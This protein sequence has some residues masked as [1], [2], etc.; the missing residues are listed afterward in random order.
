MS[1]INVIQARTFQLAE[2][3]GSSDTEITVKNLSDIYGKKIQMSGDIQYA[4]LEP[5][6]RDNQEIISFTWI[7]EVTSVMY[8]LTGVTRWLD[9]QPDP[10]TGLYG[11]DI[12]QAK[13]HSANAEAILSDNPQ[14]WDKKPSKDENETITA[15]WTFNESPIVPTP[16]ENSEAAT[17][18][19][20]DTVAILWSA[21]ATGGVKGISRLSVSPNVSLGA[22]TVTIATPAVF[23]KTTHGLTVNDTV[24]FTT[25]GALPTGLLPSV[26]YYVI[27]TGH[28]TDNFRVSETYGGGAVATSGTQSGTHAVT[29]TTPV[30]AWSNDPRIPTQDENDALVGTS[31]T[32][33][34]SNPF[35]T[36]EDP[37]FLVRPEYFPNSSYP[38]WEPLSIWNVVFIEQSPATEAATTAQNVWDITWNTRISF[39][40]FG[41]WLSDNTLKLNMSKVWSPSQSL[42]VR[43][44]TDNA[45]SPSG[46][47]VHTNASWTVLPAS[48]NSNTF[49]WTATDPTLVTYVNAYSWGTTTY[50][51]FRIETKWR[52]LLTQVVK[53]ALSVDA[54]VCY[55]KSDA[56]ATLATANFVWNIATFSYVLTENTFYRI[57][58]LQPINSFLAYNSQSY[59]INKTNIN[60]V[61]WSD[62]WANAWSSAYHITSITTVWVNDNSVSMA[63]SF[64][65]PAGK[66]CHAVISQV[67]DT[68]NASNY[69][70]IG[71]STNDSTTRGPKKYNW[72]TYWSM[73]TSKFNYI[74]GSLFIDVLSKTDA[75]FSYKIDW[76][77][78]S[79][80]A[81]T[82]VD[83]AAGKYPT[84]S[85]EWV[86]SNQVGMTQSATMYLRNT[87]GA[88]STT[89][90]ENSK[91]IGK[92]INASK[93]QLYPSPL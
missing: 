84:I 49:L 67:S 43:I 23:T 10:D 68:V 39:P 81:V 21:D 11:S 26:T 93:I 24:Q 36:T 70:K 8:R 83:I 57:E 34:A 74:S 42:Q 71:Y 4:T 88:I 65:I 79:Q 35:V 20:V 82:E 45:W 56:G 18:A 48:L 76:F 12:E 90:G 77:G 27:A 91:K 19:Y 6:S 3:I 53:D 87:S 16:T 41:S 37:R 72:S 33:G 59:P 28:T 62:N 13:A 86:D 32:P 50:K 5:Q 80:E 38:A 75:N 47:L 2:P 51:W 85:I 66:K 58:C 55:L 61:S 92:A 31:W 52:L 1:N 7:T 44:E 46:T 30:A 40:V 25:D 29:K 64:S 63:W 78:I 22:F 14:V 73:E 69:Y 9:A 54:T 89:P 15:P 17:K 60:F